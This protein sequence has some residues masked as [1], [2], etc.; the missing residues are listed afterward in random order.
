MYI[1]YYIN[2]MNSNIVCEN[3]INLVYQFWI[4]FGYYTFISFT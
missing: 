4:M 1:L 3:N 2:F